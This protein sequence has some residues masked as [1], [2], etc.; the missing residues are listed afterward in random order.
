MSKK[1]LEGEIKGLNFLLLEQK[2]QINALGHERD[3]WKHMA[4]ELLKMAGFEVPETDG[5]LLRD[6]DGK[7]IGVE[8]IKEDFLRLKRNIEKG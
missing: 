5:P 4:T 6:E 3:Y 8:S 1:E 2:D 7:L